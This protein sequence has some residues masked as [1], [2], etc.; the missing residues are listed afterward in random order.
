MPE[1]GRP[2]RL[3]VGRTEAT[4]DG[5][6]LRWIR[7]DGVE[8]LR[9]ILLTARDADWRTLVPDIRGLVMTKG[10]DAFSIDFEAR[11]R[12]EGLAVDARVAYR[13]D[14]AG[15]IEASFD[16]QVV[17]DSVV[18]RLGLVVLHPADASG[19]PFEAFDD[20]GEVSLRGR[21]PELV[22]PER[23]PTSIARAALGAGERDAGDALVRRRALGDRGPA[24]LDRRL[25]QE[26]LAPDRLAAPG[27]AR[28]RG[29]RPPRGPVGG[30]ADGRGGSGGLGA[31]ASRSHG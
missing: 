10:T 23:V 6:G 14:A 21:F 1:G 27:R 31:K 25:V 24:G 4:F 29:R 2:R 18:Q 17:A 5:G 15:G 20:A 11:F 7:V 28:R 8:V 22:S 26:L 19:R 16:G 9:G 3:R 12:G 13:G 30:G